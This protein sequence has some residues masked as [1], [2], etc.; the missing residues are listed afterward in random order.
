MQTPMQRPASESWHG[1]RDLARQREAPA[2]PEREC[3]GTQCAFPER[4]LRGSPW[5][6]DLPYSL[7]PRCY[8]GT[9]G[10]ALLLL[11][12]LPRPRGVCLILG[13]QG[14]LAGQAGSGQGSSCMGD[15]A[16]EV[17]KSPL[18]SSPNP[19]PATKLVLKLLV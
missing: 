1:A 17:G 16:A 2:P 10:L 14:H 15:S 7:P 9:A 6:G 4:E 3:A 13:L 5:V 8:Y 12:H 11:P 18:S 19:T